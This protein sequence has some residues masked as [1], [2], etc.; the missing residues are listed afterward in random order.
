[1]GIDPSLT[2]TG[3][4]RAD[5]S[6][7]RFGG[8]S[9][10]GDRRLLTIHDTVDAACAED[11]PH[12]VVI[13]YAPHARTGSGS[14]GL[15]QCAVRMPLARR[16]IPYVFVAPATLKKY[17]TGSGRGDKSELRMQL[18]KR[19][20]IDEPDDNKVDAW[21]LRHAGLD[22]YG[23]PEITLPAVQRGC[24]SKVKWPGLVEQR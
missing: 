11:L 22:W 8:D 4:A 21:W 18:F 23:E 24:L 12:L 1:M 5:G 16:R 13:E 15:V 10:M 17:A 14:L 2:A 19:T 6:L 3:M 7:W 9:S 20:G